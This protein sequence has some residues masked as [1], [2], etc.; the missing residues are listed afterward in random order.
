MTR[1]SPGDRISNQEIPGIVVDDS[2]TPTGMVAVIY[3]DKVCSDV[4]Y[5]LPEHLELVAREDA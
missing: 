2:D 5:V 1:F 3:W 4:W